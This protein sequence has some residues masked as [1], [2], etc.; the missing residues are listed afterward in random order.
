MK[1]IAKKLSQ[2]INLR[3][4]EKYKRKIK[5]SEFSTFYNLEFTRSITTETARK[6]L[7]GASAPRLS[8][9]KDL[10]HWLKMDL[11]NLF[12]DE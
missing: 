1:R 7:R 4:E 9:I 11:S 10:K 2:E 6:W 5:Y 8:V 12:D 3:L